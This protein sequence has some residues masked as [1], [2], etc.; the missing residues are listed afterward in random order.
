MVTFYSKHAEQRMVQRNISKYDIEKVIYSGSINKYK[1][2]AKSKY[3]ELGKLKVI[4]S[5][6]DVIITAFSDEAHDL[7]LEIQALKFEADLLANEFRQYFENASSSFSDGFKA[8]AKHYS[9]I[10]HALK[11]AC[12]SLNE[13]IKNLT[14]H[15]Y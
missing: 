9:L 11:D 12:I 5:I 15:V 1:S 13:H 14:L 7:K 10:G 2:T 6:D 8:E 3:Y 4:V